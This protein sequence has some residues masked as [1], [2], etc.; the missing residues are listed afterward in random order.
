MEMETMVEIIPLRQNIVSKGF[1]LH[2]KNFYE[3]GLK[4]IMYVG[5]RERLH[6]H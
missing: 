6:F 4:G 5:P 1:L 2:T 3:I